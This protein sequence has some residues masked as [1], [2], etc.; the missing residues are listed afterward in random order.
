MLPLPTS[1][2]AETPGLLDATVDIVGETVEPLYGF[3][4]LAA[5]KD[6]FH[7][8]H[9]PGTSPT[10]DEL[11]LPAIDLAVSGCYLPQL[12]AINAVAAVR[13]WADTQAER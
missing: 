10:E 2:E 7:P 12:R 13:V 9:Q 1:A 6:R 5:S 4:S 3:R 8:T 11:A